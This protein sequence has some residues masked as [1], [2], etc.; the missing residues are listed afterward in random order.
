MLKINDK[1]YETKEVL[2]IEIGDKAYSLPLAK[3]LPYKTVK[4]LSLLKSSNNDMDTIFEVLST[5]IPKEELEELS[6][7]E[8]TTIVGAWSEANNEDGTDLKN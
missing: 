2:K 1:L 6:I 8:I 5:Y 3:Y 7:A 4:K